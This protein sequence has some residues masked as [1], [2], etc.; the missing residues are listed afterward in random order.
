[1]VL[2]PGRES[3]PVPDING[4]TDPELKRAAGELNAWIEYLLHPESNDGPRIYRYRHPANPGE[5][6][7]ARRNEYQDSR[8]EEY[9]T[10]SVLERYAGDTRAFFRP[11]QAVSGISHP[12]IE[13]TY[14]KLTKGFFTWEGIGPDG[15]GTPGDKQIA[16]R[17]QELNKARGNWQ[18][19]RTGSGWIGREAHSAHEF[20]GD[21]IEFQLYT[22]NCCYE[23]AL[24][25]A[26]YR[27]IFKTAT[28]DIKNLMFGL[29]DKF[30]TFDPRPSGAGVSFDILSIVVTGL[31]AAT[32]TVIT[33]GA[34][35][36]MA[37]V[38]L[39][40]A[41]E[42]LGEAAKTA[43]ADYHLR[44]PQHLRD[45]AQEYLDAVN[46]IERD[47]TE[48]VKALYASLQHE[49]KKLR[50][51]RTYEAVPNTGETATSVPRYPHYL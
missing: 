50:D 9:E 28:E 12:V 19:M 23:V 13:Q 4:D 44:S 51:A 26:R 21:F 43:K 31:V 35:T 30:A 5:T 7:L 14:A 15:P 1:M 36:A 25:L 17:H 42:A 8:P 32:T 29:T 34:G 2:P 48:A 45:V 49:L 16:A 11:A 6:E 20:E 27:A 3:S 33:G 22:E 40:T 18:Q 46:K 24:H 39:V 37:T 38:A 47:V 10:V 41:V